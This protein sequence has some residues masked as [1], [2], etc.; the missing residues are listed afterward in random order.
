MD[1]LNSISSFGE[2]HEKPEK[3]SKADQLKR[4]RESFIKG[5][6]QQVRSITWGE[7]AKRTDWYMVK[8]TDSGDKEFFVA[9]RNG[10]KV[11]P[12]SDQKT[13]IRI[14]SRERAID[15]YEKAILACEQGDL[16]D[17]LSSTR[18]KSRK[19]KAELQSENQEG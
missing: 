7:V 5:C 19:V 17:L 6:N 18:R 4:L 11:I 2:L 15:F 1:F 9:L 16:D 10:V 8:P 3:F 12:L 14:E 13:Y